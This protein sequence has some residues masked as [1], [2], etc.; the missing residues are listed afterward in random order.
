MLWCTF[1]LLSLTSPALA[2][3][4]LDAQLAAAS[5]AYDAAHAAF[6]AGTGTPEAVYRWSRRWLASAKMVEPAKTAGAV[7]DH[8]AR[9]LQLQETITVQVQQGTASAASLAEARYYVAEAAV[10]AER[11]GPV[12]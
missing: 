10:W 11:S 2:E 1:F 6:T 5:S 4:A 7:A 3:D 8:Q 9:M 12:E